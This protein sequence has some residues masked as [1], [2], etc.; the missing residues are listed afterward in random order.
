ML[1]AMGR[2]L[3][4]LSAPNCNVKVS[5]VIQDVQPLKDPCNI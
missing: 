4:D 1:E 5:G 3:I 2:K